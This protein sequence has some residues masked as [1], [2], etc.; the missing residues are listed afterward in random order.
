MP[1]KITP[2]KDL[3]LSRLG[4]QEEDKCW[5]WQGAFKPNGYGQVT[6]GGRSGIGGH[7][8]YAHR[9]AYTLFVG[10]IPEGLLIC[11]KCDNRKCCN[12]DHL[13]LG[14]YLDN[15]QD[16]ARKDRSAFGERQASHKLTESDVREIRKLGNSVAQS[17]IA[18]VYGIGQPQVS[19]IIR[20]QQW[21]RQV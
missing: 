14:D 5:E 19:R 17:T 16:M 18:S 12:P 8:W 4:P 11:H 7:K 9:L 15:Q 3:F 6:V 21:Q 1:K 13:F 20:R 2:A 10:P